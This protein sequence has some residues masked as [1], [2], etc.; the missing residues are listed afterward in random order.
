MPDALT[1]L[2]EATLRRERA[3]ERVRAAE[4]HLNALVRGVPLRYG[5]AATARLG[6]ALA[7]AETAERAYEAAQDAPAP[8]D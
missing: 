8:Q 7:L 5:V 1:N 2:T 6:D 4:A 3:Q